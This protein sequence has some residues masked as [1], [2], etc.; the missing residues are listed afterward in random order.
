MSDLECFTDILSESLEDEELKEFIMMHEWKVNDFLSTFVMFRIFEI[1]DEIPDSLN[2]SPEEFFDGYYKP[3]FK[4]YFCE[5]KKGVTSKQ[6]SLIDGKGEEPRTPTYIP[7][8]I[9]LI[10][11]VEEFFSFHI[12]EIIRMINSNYRMLDKYILAADAIEFA[13]K[14]GWRIPASVLSM[15]NRDGL[16]A[17]NLQDSKESPYKSMSELITQIRS[18]AGKQKGKQMRAFVEQVIKPLGRG[19]LEKGCTCLHRELA[20]HLKN[21][22]VA[23]AK[24]FFGPKKYNNL[25]SRL[26]SIIADSLKDLFYECEQKYNN[27]EER[28]FRGNFYDPKHPPPPC[29]IHKSGK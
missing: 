21:E 16:Q 29:K 13:L 26:A 9:G 12:G 20:N 5:F 22:V 6:I 8:K 25:E 27:V 7:W 3:Y 4:E 11:N 28:V 10:W 18:A 24:T 2:Q 23:K 14:E 15:V 17:P 19:E 1:K